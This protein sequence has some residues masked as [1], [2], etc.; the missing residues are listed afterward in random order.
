LLLAGGR[1]V[2]GKFIPKIVTVAAVL[3]WGALATLPA[4]AATYDVTFT[5]SSLDLSA[6]VTTA[7]SLDSLGGYNILSI[8]GNVTG[9][10]SG[11]ISGR[12]ANPS[13]PTQ[14]TY[15]DPT[16][17]LAWNYDNVLFQTSIPFDNNGILFSFGNDIVANL[18]SVGSA[19]YL[20]VRDPTSLWDPGAAGWRRK[21]R[22]LPVSAA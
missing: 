8:I 13:E 15:T 14:R 18:Y 10:T 11:A 5:S 17:G 3:G 22:A 7:N 6:V 2:I 12:I 20:S 1:A 19:F 4:N 21:P 16:T 9:V